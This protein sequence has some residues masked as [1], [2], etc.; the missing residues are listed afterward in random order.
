MVNAHDA[1]RSYLI[2][3]SALRTLLGGDYVYWPEV[4]GGGD[5]AMPT[6]AIS[7]RGSG[8]FT[9]RNLGLQRATVSVKAW[10]ETAENAMAVYLA[11]FDRLHQQQNV[12]VDG[13][14]FYNIV[15]DVP[16]QPL[17]DPVSHWPYVFAVFALAV[18]TVAIPSA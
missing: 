2:A 11:L 15:E 6:K 9:E 13:V 12:L 1:L 5:P 10:G 4:P 8:G 18:A 16:G 7:F 14:G 3:P 17:E